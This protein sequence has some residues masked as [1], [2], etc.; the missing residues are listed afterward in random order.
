MKKFL[1]DIVLKH[2][3]TPEKVLPLVFEWLKGEWEKGKTSVAAF[4]HTNLFSKI[5]GERATQEE[6]IAAVEAF[7]DFLE[8]AQK[9]KAWKEFTARAIVLTK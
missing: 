3:L 7:E 5:W 4:L 6:A 9:L 1:F 2:F 8:E